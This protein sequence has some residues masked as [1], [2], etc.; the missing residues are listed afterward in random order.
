MIH[1][2]VD[3]YG[4]EVS[5]SFRREPFSEQPWH[6]LVL[7]RFKN[8]W[9]LT[10][11]PRRGLEFPGGKVEKG[12]VPEGAAIREV[13]E[14]TGA[15]INDLH[16]L[17]QYEVRGRSDTVVKNVYFADI[18]YLQTKKGY[19]ET[20]GPSLL[21]TIPEKLENN[22]DFSFIMKDNVW[23]MTKEYVEHHFL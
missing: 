16:Y 8:Q 19:M 17:G 18:A 15:R 9:L 4:N 14:E 23:K 10:K 13:W 11:H 22:R 7:C 12:E 2:F 6:V 21:E 5:L 20:K 3:Y 1:T